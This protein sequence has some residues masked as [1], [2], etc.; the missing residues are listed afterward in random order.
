M[1]FE[2]PE[3]SGLSGPNQR[4]LRLQRVQESQEPKS[5]IR[6]L[7]T[8]GGWI[9]TECT[10]AQFSEDNAF[11]VKPKLLVKSQDLDASSLAVHQ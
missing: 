10:R 7:S 9:C 5:V 8:V 1:K 2:N 4:V 6:N 11:V 3:L